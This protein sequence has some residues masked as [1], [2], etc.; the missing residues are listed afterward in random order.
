MCMNVTVEVRGEL[1]GI[2]S[3]L[4]SCGSH[5]LNSGPKVWQ[6]APFTTEL[7]WWSWAGF[8]Y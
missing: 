5:I 8:I 6:K 4:A 3:F 1:E 2:G 7:S